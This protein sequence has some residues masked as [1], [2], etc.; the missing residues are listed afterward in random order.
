MVVG[1]VRQLSLL[2]R[3]KVVIPDVTDAAAGVQVVEALPVR[4]PQRIATVARVNDQRTKLAR[5]EHELPD[6]TRS[7]SHGLHTL[8]VKLVAPTREEDRRPVRAHRGILRRNVK[9][10]LLRGA[11]IGP[12]DDNAPAGLRS[13]R[14]AE[15][16]TQQAVAART[17]RPRPGRFRMVGDLT[18]RVLRHIELEDL[19]ASVTIGRK[20]DLRAV[21]TH[22]RPGIGGLTRPQTARRTALR[23]R[24]PQVVVPFEGKGMPVAADTRIRPE[25]DARPILRRL[26]GNCR[27]QAH[28]GICKNRLFHIPLCFPPA[29][30]SR[31]RPTPS[32]SRCVPS[33]DT[34]STASPSEPRQNARL[35]TSPC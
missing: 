16:L 33:R 21:R 27:H 29:L 11:S 6:L 25:V 8:A 12:D 7:R 17:P 15:R 24:H 32:R 18:D 2:A 19:H 31:R 22:H 13:G 35:P 10:N 26:R 5:R 9:G 34:R 1:E 14:I 28:K 3:R 23:V 30:T 20:G 4:T